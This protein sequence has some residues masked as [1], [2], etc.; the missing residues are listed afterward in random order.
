[1]YK[2]FRLKNEKYKNLSF[3]LPWC[4]ENENYLNLLL[5]FA[6]VTHSL[7]IALHLGY[8]SGSH[9]VVFGYVF[10]KKH[11]QEGDFE[12]TKAIWCSL[13]EHQFRLKKILF[14]LRSSE[15]FTSVRRDRTS[16]WLVGN[17][18]I[19]RVV[20]ITKLSTWHEIQKIWN[21]R[22]YPF[23]HYFTQHRCMIWILKIN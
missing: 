20:I 11:L 17:L 8:T 10:V 14:E 12:C 6:I 2:N 7:S 15:G 4:M 9:F 22:L 16:A 13:E 18:V 3:R 5:W 1:M 19:E 21:S 23:S